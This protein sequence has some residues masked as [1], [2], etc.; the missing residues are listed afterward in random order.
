MDELIKNVH[1]RLQTFMF[2]LVFLLRLINQKSIGMK[3]NR[4][5][6]MIRENENYTEGEKVTS[7]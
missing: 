4:D 2:F 7:V 1:L 5:R 6:R 3:R